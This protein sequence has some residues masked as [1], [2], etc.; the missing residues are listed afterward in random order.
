MP[1]SQV[2]LSQ[3]DPAVQTS[4]ANADTALTNANTAL[5]TL[6]P[7]VQGAFKKLKIVAQ[8][9]TNTSAVVTADEVILEDTSNAYAIARNV[10]V[11]ANLTVSGA[12][13]LDTGTSA[14]S[15]WYSVWV[16]A[17]PDGT[18]A[19]LLSASATSP[20]MPTGYTFKA[21]LGWVRTDGT[22]NKYLLQTVQNG[23]R[24]Q[25]VVTSSSNVAGLPLMA[26]GVAG[27]VAA[28]PTWVAVATGTFVPS[29]AS[30]LVGGV[31]TTT[32]GGGGTQFAIA[33]PNNA[34]GGSLTSG[35]NPP[36]WYSA[37]IDN[38][39]GIMTGV[40]LSHSMPLESSNIQWASSAAAGRLFCSGWEDNL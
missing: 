31:Y 13:G 18:V 37:A 26:S 35:S 34:Y 32:S 36:P 15:T 21:R 8:G 19:G 28:T 14:T 29:T 20:T 22:V 40:V 33:A 27:A 11:T 39:A 38:G 9:L 24:A 5:A 17:K 25:Y 4:L 7:G 6:S 1:L 30:I 3:L 16:I 2:P 12:N 23:N 10:N